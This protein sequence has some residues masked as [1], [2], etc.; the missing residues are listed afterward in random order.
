MRRKKIQVTF[1]ER[2]ERDIID[3]LSTLKKQEVH[4]VIAGA[5]RGYMRNT[6]FYDAGQYMGDSWVRTDP[7]ESVSDDED[8]GIAD[9][10][11][12]AVFASIEEF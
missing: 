7:P 6:G 9:S 2:T 8:T 10:K 3:F 5:V 4:V 1:S 12:F 11:A